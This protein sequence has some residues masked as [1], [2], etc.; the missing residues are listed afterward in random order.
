MIISFDAENALSKTQ[1]PLIIK[2]L[3]LG[4]EDNFHNL[5]KCMYENPQL[6]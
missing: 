4:T 6:K 5:I 3:K 1:H 2:T